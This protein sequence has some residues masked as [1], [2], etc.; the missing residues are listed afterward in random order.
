MVAVLVFAERDV[1]ARLFRRLKVR[2]A[3]VAQHLCAAHHAG[4]GRQAGQALRGERVEIRLFGQLLHNGVRSVNAAAARV[5]NLEVLHQ[6]RGQQRA[7]C[8]RRVRAA[9]HE[10]PRGYAW[11]EEHLVGDRHAARLPVAPHQ[12]CTR[13]EVAAGTLPHQ[14]DSVAVGVRNED[15]GGL[16]T[17]P[18]ED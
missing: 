18:R 6:P 13:G 3:L 1:H 15:R 17:E 14:D 9:G 2:H 12:A 11:G 5:G 16:V 7:V 10:R 8:A 4:D